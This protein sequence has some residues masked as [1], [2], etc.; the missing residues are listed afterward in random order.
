M[1]VSVVLMDCR[2]LLLT[3]SLGFQRRICPTN[4]VSIAFHQQAWRE[5]IQTE[6]FLPAAIMLRSDLFT[7]GEGYQVLHGFQHQCLLICSLQ[8]VP[9]K[10]IQPAVLIGQLAASLYCAEAPTF[11][12][13]T[14]ALPVKPLLGNQRVT[15]CRSE[16]F[17]FESIALVYVDLPHREMRCL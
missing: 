2:V 6:I 17:L 12:H 11:I 3:Y 7:P 10:V 15:V 14:L 9:S 1:V 13:Q 16:K 5:V 8:L 4:G